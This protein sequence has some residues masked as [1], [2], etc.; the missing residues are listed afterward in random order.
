MARSRKSKPPRTPRGKPRKVPR[1]L[2][3]A[4][5]RERR[6][7][8]ALAASEARFRALV[9]YA[10]DAIMLLDRSGAVTWASQSTARVLGWRLHELE[11]RSVFAFVHPDDDP[12][13]R[14][15]LE[16]CLAQPGA[17]VRAELRLRNQDGWFRHVEGVIVNRLH[18][19]AVRAV[20]ANV[21]DIGERK[22]VERQLLHDALH[23]PLTG[24]PNRTLLMSRLEHAVEQAR[25][26]AGYRFALLFVDLDGFKSVND[27]FGHP[28]GDQVLARVARR[29]AECLR[30]GDTLARMGGDE[31]AVLLDGV[32]GEGSAALVSDRIDRAMREPFAVG[33]REVGLAASIGIAY[34]GEGGAAAAAMLDEADQAMYRAKRRRRRSAS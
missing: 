27:R 5:A 10:Y 3:L 22:T 33:D 20:V 6:A 32:S 9:E 1:A 28:A 13:A 4:R 11:E 26:R 23:D 34:D 31:F 30:P 17:V 14:E 8:R 2:A 18:E 15:A 21:R 24:L 29:I 7:R 12:R 16:A 25:R 19:P